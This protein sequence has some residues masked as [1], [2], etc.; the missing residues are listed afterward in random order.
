MSKITVT[1]L[2]TPEKATSLLSVTSVDFCIKFSKWVM[3]RYKMQAAQRAAASNLLWE[4]NKETVAFKSW[5]K[6]QAIV[7][8]L[9]PRSASIHLCS[10]CDCVLVGTKGQGG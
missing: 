3:M 1:T 6:K 9:H 7:H 8:N 2:P 10:W 5:W 4:M